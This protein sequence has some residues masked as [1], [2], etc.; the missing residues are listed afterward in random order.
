[1]DMPES[2][3]ALFDSMEYFDENKP[4]GV[5]TKSKLLEYN[6]AIAFLKAYTGSAG[7]FISYRR[8]LERLFQ[9]SWNIKKT[10]IKNIKREDLEEYINFCKKPPKSWI[11]TNKVPK[12]IQ[13][14]GVRTPN[15][16]WRP[17]IVTIPKREHRQG[18]EPKIKN[19]E[20]SPETIKEMFAILNSF[21][22]FLLQEGYALSNPISLMRQKSKFI[23]SKQNPHKIRRLTELQWEYLINTATQMADEK[24]EQHE[25]TLFIISI[26][27]AMYLRISELSAT[28]RWVPLMYH[29][30]RDNEENWWFITVGKGNKERHIAVSKAM[31]QTLKRWRAHLNL[32]PLPSPSDKTPL[33]PKK[34]GKEPISSV[35]YIR[36]IVQGCFDKTMERLTQDGFTEDAESFSA[37]TV[38]W[39]RHTGISDDVKIR[40]KEHV[41][42][43]AGHNSGATTDRYIDVALKER[44]RSTPKKPISD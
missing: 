17:F 11:G 26:F 8:E 22:N 31:L 21:Y 5:K 14:T 6:S 41:R 30:Y 2:P 36:R 27:Y 18:H 33:L 12:F 43:D 32:T 35:N 37:A 24:P 44:H 34:N 10:S 39:L 1:M 40:P 3:V 28:Q 4:I 16:A 23:R 15:P 13:K 7:T 9:W 25:R 19:F 29:F 20:L 42:D 38:H